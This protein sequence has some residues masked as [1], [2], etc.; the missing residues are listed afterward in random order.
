MKR[1]IL[2]VILSITMA[3]STT[4]YAFADVDLDNPPEEPTKPK[5]E[6]YQDNDK[7]EK[8]NKEAEEYNKKADEYNA[9]VDEEY[10]NAKAEVDKQNTEGEA[11]Q[12]ASQKAHDEA[13]ATNE[14]EQNRVDEANKKI[15]EDNA[16]EEQRIKEENAQKQAKYDAEYEQYTKD[17]DL[18]KQ[19]LDAGYESVDQYNEAVTAYNA[20]VQKYNN[21][22][23]EYNTRYENEIQK[24][25]DLT[26]ASVGKGIESVTENEEDL[27]DAN[28]I[29]DNITLTTNPKTIKVESAT[30]PSGEKYK[31][32]VQH[33]Y[34]DGDLFV[35]KWEVI[36]ADYNDI[37]TIVPEKAILTPDDLGSIAT[38][39]YTDE[40]HADGYWIPTIRFESA[41][42]TKNDISVRGDDYQGPIY[43]F[44]YK[45]GSI[46]ATGDE[47]DI[48]LVYE[49]SYWDY[50][51]FTPYEL[52]DFYDYANVPNKPILNLETFI[53]KEHE[54]PNFIGVP[55]VEVWEKLPD[56]VKREYLKRLI[57]MSLFAVPN[58]NIEDDINSDE[59][60]INDDE[61]I[62]NK[63]NSK[64]TANKTQSSNNSSTYVLEENT[65]T[66]DIIKRSP[67]PTA[68]TPL[69]APEQTGAWAFINLLTVLINFIL[70]IILLLMIYI[71]NR[72]ED[73]ETEVK[74]KTLMRICTLI[75]AIISG[76]VF[77]LTEDMTLPM[78]LID[79]WT[80]LMIIILI[81]N[82]IA[83]ILSRRRIKEKEE[84]EKE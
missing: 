19:I 8:Y 21:S 16:A 10:N 51:W 25:K 39:N 43:Q 80:P 1:K 55:N 34:K 57:L 47:K 69:V 6:N 29:S 35:G 2:T 17:K 75:I 63:D 44:S 84:I 68:A 77:L 62:N 7:I 20:K 73:D 33:I 5:V 52:R 53:P 24:C 15:D 27:P 59:D 50:S 9:A 12:E 48:V 49:Y 42:Q 46:H 56:P 66:N 72:K 32:M 18:E 4:G 22:V 3:F 54:I 30:E 37:I 76:I 82:I 70:S 40:A 61:T 81:F 28:N 83:A 31:I 74:N 71:N 65:E 14:A 45:D 38:Y 58:D 79:K 64:K 67:L 36:E 11:K 23:T 60:I 26:A 13:V 41:A 78:V